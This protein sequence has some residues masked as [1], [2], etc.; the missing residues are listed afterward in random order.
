MKEL[1]ANYHT[2]TF[3]CNHAS[4]TEREYIER[5]IEAGME[6][7]GFSD[8]VPYPGMKGHYSTY[9]MKPEQ[10]Q[11]YVETLKTLREE[12]KGKI[13]ILIGY[14]AEYY[15][16]I[17]PDMC[18]FLEQFGYDYLILGQH[19]V[20]DSGETFYSGNPHTEESV[21]ENYVNQVLEG[22]KTGKYLYM[23]H[24][25]VIRFE[26]EEKV[27]RKHMGRLCKEMKEMGLPVE[28]NMLG[29]DDSRYYPK[30]LFFE[31]VGEV[32]TKVVVGCDAHQPRQ[33]GDQE[34]LRRAH[35]IIDKFSLDFTDRLLI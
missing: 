6:V 21:L 22:M 8:H 19:F 12:Y 13:E 32:G 15:P 27:Y 23:A 17:F 16:D 33:I 26:G 5:A 24:P 35:E 2:H 31:I 1:K 28:I 7:L 10:T 14:E 29:I 25:D 11:D 4:G 34:N 9:R 18:D 20:G 30:E 3:R